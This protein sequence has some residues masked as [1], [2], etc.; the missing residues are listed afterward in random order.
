MYFP[1]AGANARYTRHCCRRGPGSHAHADTY[2]HTGHTGHGAGGGTGCHGGQTHIDAGSESHRYTR[3]NS[4][5][6]GHVNAHRYTNGNADPYSY[7]YPNGDAAAYPYSNS[8]PGNHGGAGKGR[9][10]S[11]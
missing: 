5:A 11:D 1:T 7:P 3:A 2:P 9:G 10:G 4:P 6:Y 8:E